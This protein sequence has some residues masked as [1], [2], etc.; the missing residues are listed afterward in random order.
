MSK[1]NSG[2]SELSD[3]SPED[4]MSISKLEQSSDNEIWI[5]NTS[6]GEYKGQVNFQA[7]SQHGNPVGLAIPQTWVAINLTE[8]TSKSV[9]LSSESF[10]AAVRKK[11]ITIITPEYAAEI[12]SREG[13]SSELDMV[14][15]GISLG[16]RERA[17][18]A[19]G[20]R[21]NFAVEVT[22]GDGAEDSHQ[23]A[24]SMIAKPILTTMEDTQLSDS[25]KVDLLRTSKEDIGIL[26]AL[27]IERYCRERGVE[28]E[29]MLNAA[30]VL[31]ASR[32]KRVSREEYVSANN[33]VS[34]INMNY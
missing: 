11:M 25:K 24:R 10:R 31:V 17:M 34:L 30:N 19:E 16:V 20:S 18:I 12:N 3:M 13:A 29:E 15:K 14:A 4:I 6:T 33:T 32:S 2:W 26:E 21:P 22:T 1:I 5:L 27:Y 8:E 7:F 9:I 28:N 23:K